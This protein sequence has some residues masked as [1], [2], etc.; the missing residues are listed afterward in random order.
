MVE[1]KKWWA[2][3]KS[4]PKLRTYVKFK[5]Q[6]LRVEKYLYTQGYYYGRSLMAGIR[7]GT[8]KLEVEMGR[9]EGKHVDLRL[10]KQCNSNQVEDEFHFITQCPL[11]GIL[12][13]IVFRYLSLYK[14]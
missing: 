5:N 4:Q 8:N 6:G 3:V 2:E 9:R 7:I 14:F 13:Q 12:R 11:Y 10:C 1:E